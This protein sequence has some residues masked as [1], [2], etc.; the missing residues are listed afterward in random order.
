MGSSAKKIKKE[1]KN[2]KAK[3]SRESTT[4]KEQENNNNVMSKAAAVTAQ[5]FRAITVP[6]VL[7]SILLIVLYVL[8]YGIVSSVA[9]LLF[10]LLFLGVVPLLAYPIAFLIPT[11]RAKGREGQR[12]LAFVMNLLGYAGA[13]AY[14]LIARVGE[15]LLLIF[16]TYCISVLVLMFF[17]KVLKVRA[18][19]HAC[20]VTGPL[21]FFV[22]FTGPYG[23]VPCVIIAAFVVWSSLRLK[24]HTIAELV[25]GAVIAFVSFAISLLILFLI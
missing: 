5:I 16:L 13:L 7:V 6:P 1:D 8:N 22:Y 3:L 25:L 12:K 15:G 20:G 21:I 10:S 4:Y 2:S 24:R 17:N 19:G 18:S 14:G 9:E 11:V 23:I